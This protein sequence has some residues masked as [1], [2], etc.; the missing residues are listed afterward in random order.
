MK[1]MMILID[2]RL[3]S[4]PNMI[5]LKRV[6]GDGRKILNED[7]DILVSLLDEQGIQSLNKSQWNDHSDKWNDDN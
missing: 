1:D 5:M 4:M 7:R 2:K 6:M 3:I